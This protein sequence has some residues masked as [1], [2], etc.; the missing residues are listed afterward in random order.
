LK[1]S[2]SFND[3]ERGERRRRYLY[4]KIDIGNTGFKGNTVLAG[5]QKV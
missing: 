5:F 1:F 3:C 2:L 4:L